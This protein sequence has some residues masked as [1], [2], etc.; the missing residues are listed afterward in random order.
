MQKPHIKKIG[1][2]LV[3]SL[4][5]FFLFRPD[6]AQI[7]LT[8]VTDYY[9]SLPGGIYGIE[10]TQDSEIPGFE[11]DF[12]FYA[13]ERNESQSAIRKYR[14]SIIK[15]EDLK[16]GYLRLEGKGWDGW[17]EIALFKKS[18]ES[19]V[20]AISQVGCGPGSKGGLLFATYKNSKWKNVTKQVFPYEVQTENYY[21]LPRTGTTIELICGDDSNKTC[22]NGTALG[23][24]KWNREKFIEGT[25]GRIASME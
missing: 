23:K 18:D 5:I 9:L 8:T 24:F 2:T 3:L 13:N 25:Q 10:G 16:N 14:K 6:L 21:K 20:V 17:V 15:I 12:F 7:N 11:D 22:R 19:Y 4:C 1:K